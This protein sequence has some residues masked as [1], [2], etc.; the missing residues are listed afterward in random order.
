MRADFNKDVG[1]SWTRWCHSMLHRASSWRDYTPSYGHILDHAN[2]FCCDECSPGKAQ[3]F[4][5]I[6][7]KRAS[8]KK[9]K[10]K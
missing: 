10:R 3:E 9:K 5:R 4:F 2:M 1:S 7:N 8:K 6:M